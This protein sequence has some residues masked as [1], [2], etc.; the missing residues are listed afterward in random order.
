MLIKFCHSLVTRISGLAEEMMIL[1]IACL[2][3]MW[4]FVVPLA[5]AQKAVPVKR[6]L[7]VGVNNAPPFA[8]K[9]SDGAWSGLS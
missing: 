6:E 4:L 2:A 3:L 9:G 8:M 7:V 5:H 1:R